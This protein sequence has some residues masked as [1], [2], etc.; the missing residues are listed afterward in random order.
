MRVLIDGK[1][2]GDDEASISVFDWA[3]QRG[4]GAF[5]LIRSYAGVPFRLDRHLDRLGRSLEIMH[6]DAPDMGDV[7]EWA[8][9]QAA[10]G[11]DC[12]VRIF[13]TAG[14]RDSLYP[15]ASRTVVLWEE[16]PDLPD[17]FRFLPLPAPWAPGGSP[18]PRWA[19]LPNHPTSGW[20]TSTV[21]SIKRTWCSSIR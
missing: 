4:Y 17:E 21:G 13:V 6:I 20:I 18:C 15:S 10:A 12:F 7:D 19:A 2:H 3:L 8:R 9:R 11:G 1:P 5:E 14:S 16:M